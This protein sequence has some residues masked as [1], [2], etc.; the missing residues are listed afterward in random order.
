MLD[1]GVEIGNIEVVKS[2]AARSLHAGHA[3]RGS[4]AGAV[5][6][7]APELSGQDG[8]RG[9]VIRRLLIDGPSTATS[10]AAALGVSGTAVRR[11]L[12][13]LVAEGSV[14]TRDETVRGARGRGRPAQVYLLTELGRRRLPHAYDELAEQALDYLQEHGGP[15]AV[16]EFARRRAQR[17][18]GG[19]ADELSAAQSVGERARIVA[20][21]LSKS[22]YVANV[23]S[24]AVGQQLS[25]H[26]CPV[27]HVAGKYPQLCE[28]E[29][30]VF[31]EALGT[32]AQRLA[33]IARGDSFCTTFIP[34]D[35]TAEAAAPGAVS[36]A[37]GNDATRTSSMHSNGRTS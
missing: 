32:Y 1:R 28:Q 21:A 14:T 11:H 31:T 3:G 15:Q 20:K 13:A 29:L 6:A 17:I 26:H 30:A 33:T 34:P 36:R 35:S 2:V 9:E 8:A 10:L 19:V 7:A 24:V 23:E 18:L 4:A 16:E 25:Q 5:A 37:R 12:D 22:G 27:A